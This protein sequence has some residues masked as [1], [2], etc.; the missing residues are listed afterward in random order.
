MKIELRNRKMS[1]ALYERHKREALFERQQIADLKRC[2]FDCNCIF[3]KCSVYRNF[4]N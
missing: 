1:A 2:D 4:P 3:R